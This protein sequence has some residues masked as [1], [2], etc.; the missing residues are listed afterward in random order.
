[1]S[2]IAT[3]IV[4]AWKFRSISSAYWLDQYDNAKTK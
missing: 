3:F 4:R 1:M 2:R